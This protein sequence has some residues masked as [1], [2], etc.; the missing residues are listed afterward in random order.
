MIRLPFV[1]KVHAH[2][3]LEPNNK[4]SL[5]DNQPSNPTFLNHR[6]LD[7]G[8]TRNLSIGDIVGFGSLDFEFVDASRL[9]DIFHKGLL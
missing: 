2:I 5:R 7:P 1:S 3:L 8:A 9:Y 4:F 6:K